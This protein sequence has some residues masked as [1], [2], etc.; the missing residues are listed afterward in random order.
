MSTCRNLRNIFYS[1]FILHSRREAETKK[2]PA[3]LFGRSRG[4]LEV[5]LLGRLLVL[6]S[7]MFL[8]WDTLEMSF[9]KAKIC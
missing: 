7:E 9:F 2:S 1:L 4:W 5:Q 3:S 6:H 8:S